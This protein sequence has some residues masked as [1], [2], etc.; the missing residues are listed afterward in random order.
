MKKISLYICLS[1]LKFQLLLFNQNVFSQDIEGDSENVNMVNE[2]SNIGITPFLEL[3][4]DYFSNISGGIKNEDSYMLNANLGLGIDLE[5]LAGLK[6]A[7]VYL[8]GIGIK[9]VPFL[10]NTGAIQGISNIAGLNQLK[11]YEAWIEQNLFDNNFSILFG[12]YDLNSEF[13]V[14]ESSIYFIN[15]SF[16]IGFDFSQSGVNGPSVFPHTSLALRVKAR[17][18]DSFEIIGSIF[19]GVPGSQENESSFQ[20]KLSVEEGALI[21]TEIIYYSQNDF[22]KISLGGWYYTSTFETILY[23]N[24]ESGNFGAYLNAEKQIYTEESNSSK[25][26]SLFGRIGLAHNKFNPSDYS[27][28]GGVNYKGIIPGR[29]EDVFGFACS[30]IHLSD[31]FKQLHKLN[32]NFEVILELTYNLRINEWLRI[33]PDLQYILNPVLAPETDYAFVAGV[34]TEISL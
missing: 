32:S 16:G 26:L 17:L 20:V 14:R 30:S 22:T 2:L 6:A 31:K 1:Y 12:L 10:E 9:G 34:R 18:S 27:I 5:L 25:G 8:S 4:I 29:D 15:P 33:Q 24:K 23:E 28:L 3:P 19:D 21:A 11:L 7:S 13:D